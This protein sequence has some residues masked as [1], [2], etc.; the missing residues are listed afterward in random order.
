MLS[1][2]IVNATIKDLKYAKR[3]EEKAMMEPDTLNFKEL[4]PK[5]HLKIEKYLL[6]Q[7]STNRKKN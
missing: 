2:V 5:E 1:S 4:G 7:V 6:M 3:P